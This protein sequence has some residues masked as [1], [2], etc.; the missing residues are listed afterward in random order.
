LI[1]ERLKGVVVLTIHHGDVHVGASERPRRVQA[2]E[3]AAHDDHTPSFFHGGFCTANAQRV[4]GTC[5]LFAHARADADA[6]GS[7]RPSRLLVELTR[8]RAGRAPTAER[9]PSSCILV[10]AERSRVAPSQFLDQ[11]ARPAS[12]AAQTPPVGVDVALGTGAP[13]YPDG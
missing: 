4:K 7:I 6:R 1:E 13:R 2:P 12:T 9:P 5:S 10:M 3:A 8:A 11:L